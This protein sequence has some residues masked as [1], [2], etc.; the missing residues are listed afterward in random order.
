MILNTYFGL[1]VCLLKPR[2]GWT[3]AMLGYRPAQRAAF[4]NAWLSG[5]NI[6]NGFQFDVTFSID[7]SQHRSFLL[8][9]MYVVLSAAN[10]STSGYW[11]F[12]REKLFYQLSRWY[13]STGLH[14]SKTSQIP[15]YGHSN[16]VPT[17]ISVGSFMFT[18]S[19]VYKSNVV[20]EITELTLHV[21]Q[22]L[23]ERT[24]SVL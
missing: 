22:H 1:P 19:T 18:T 7:A 11:N 15:L 9:Y 6:E 20:E 3:L 10:I 14:L 12:Y 4:I 23:G 13:T 2:V 16:C 5:K 17:C 8:L 21:V 24:Y